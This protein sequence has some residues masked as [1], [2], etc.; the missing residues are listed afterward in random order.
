MLK[1]YHFILNSVCLISVLSEKAVQVGRNCFPGCTMYLHKASNVAA[2]QESF[3]F[4]FLKYLV[5]KEITQA[6]M[7]QKKINYSRELIT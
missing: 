4:L 1:I 6:G 2:I 3:F 5:R 7:Q